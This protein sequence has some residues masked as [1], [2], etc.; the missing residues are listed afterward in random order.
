MVSNEA[1]M[2]NN[3]ILTLKEFAFSVSEQLKTFLPESYASAEI[4]VTDVKKQNSIVK[5]G[6]TIR[7]ENSVIAPT[8]YLEEAFDAFKNGENLHKICMT[9]ARAIVE[10]EPK[11]EI[12][13]EE[14]VNWESAKDK[15]FPRVI[16]ARFNVELLK[17]RP[18]SMLADL[19]VVYDIRIA[20]KA[21]EVGTIGISNKMLKEN[22]KV[23]I[24]E[25]HEVALRNMLTQDDAR[26]CPIGVLLRKM[27][28]DVP[29]DMEGEVSE[30]KLL[31]LTNQKGILG[32][33]QLLNTAVLNDLAEKFGGKFC[34][35]PS[36]IHE[37]IVLKCP[38]DGFEQLTE[39]V[40]SVNESVVE[41]QDILSDH[42]YVY[43][44]RGGLQ[45]A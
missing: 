42:A 29:E 19:A 14:L 36:S 5:T 7:K 22:L 27:G 31:V 30:P 23:S 45:I 24:Q 1:L 12:Q 20:V 28:M 37:T 34:I 13:I 33:N 6:V 10:N 35:L 16:N 8:L 15:V 4:T 11:D 32:S 25:L 3:G 41:P 26:V 39:M 38:K 2:Q 9:L 18:H 43:S 44:T 21:D 17:D 40:Q